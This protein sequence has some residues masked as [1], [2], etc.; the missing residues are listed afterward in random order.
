VSAELDSAESVSAEPASSTAEQAPDQA[1]DATP[2]ATPDAAADAT[3]EAEAEV[4]VEEA[5]GADA[6]P[7]PEPAPEDAPAANS[8]AEPE[9]TPVAPPEPPRV[10]TRTRRRSASRPA[11]PPTTV[12]PSDHDNIAP[13]DVAAVA[14]ADSAEDGAPALHVPVKRKGGARKR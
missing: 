4:A 14:V 7:E 11:G 1:T 9:P 6:A 12:G 8:V 3:T 2:D 10:V 5:P 13:E